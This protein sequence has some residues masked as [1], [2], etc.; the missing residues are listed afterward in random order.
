MI[1]SAHRNSG[2]TRSSGAEIA[3]ALR[4]RSNFAQDGILAIRNFFAELKRRNVYKVAVAYAVVGWLLIQIATQTFPVFEIPNWA[5][6]LV[7]LALVIGFPVA[8]V[9]AWAYELTPEG[10]RRAEEVAPD[11]SITRSTG[12]K[13]DF[14]IIGVLLAVIVLLVSSRYSP[15]G[16]APDASADEKSVAVLPFQN[17]S[18]DKQNAYFADGVQEEILTTLAKVADLKVISR[19]SVMQFRDVEKRKL[20]E[21]GYQ[22]GVAHILEGSV[23]RTANRV[24]VTA[25][26]VDARTD[27]HVWAEHYDRELADIFAIQSEIA[28]DIAAALHATLTR[29][30]QQRVEAKPTSNAAAYDAYLRGLAVEGHFA[31]SVEDVRRRIRAYEQAVELDPRFAAAWAALSRARVD[32]YFNYEHTPER[33]AEAKTALDA[34]VNL[35]PDLGE[36][37][38]AVGR[39]RYWGLGD[40]EGAVEAYTRARQ[41]LPND[42]RIVVTLGNVKRRQGKWEE[43]LALQDRATQLDPLNNN[44][45]I[46]RGITLHTLRRYD[47]AL[48]AFD[49]GLEKKP[50]DEELLAKKVFIYQA[51]GDLDAAEKIAHLPVL[52]S[53]TNQNAF[54]CRVRQWFYRREYATAATALKQALEGANS[55]S[56]QDRAA[57]LHDMGSAELWNGEREPGLAH[58]VECRDAIEE[59]RNA[60]DDNPRHHIALADVCGLIGESQCALQ[61]ARLAIEAMAQ[62]AFSLH[63]A[64]AALARAQMRAG[65]LDGAISTLRHL[66]ETPSSV[67]PALLRLNPVWDPLR[68]D[69][70]FE[71]LAQTKP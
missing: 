56:Q 28:Q 8:L 22:L 42:A 13:I 55:L 62:D 16:T 34:A 31:S 68:G 67:S 51:K 12:R 4:R 54:E 3:T 65:D 43:A 39:F 9:F 35:E 70:R 27:S 26:L 50:N 24:R 49:R 63:H 7:I 1:A 25:Q 10:L 30:E 6:R 64:E 61:H 38:N 48:A 20:R 2:A 21:I 47:E 41:R 29:D 14:A 44:T 36:V 37:F 46:S 33:L 17:M 53:S 19:T 18:D 60:G 40:Y 32:L 15:K 58:L 66:L 59:L 71:K 11:A 5:A 23:Q 52:V 57:L 69:P 45:W